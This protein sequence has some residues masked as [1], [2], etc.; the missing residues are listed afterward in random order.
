MKNITWMYIL[1]LFAILYLAVLFYN[2]FNT[3]SLHEGFQQGEPF[4]VR[5]ENEIYDDFYVEI[6]DKLMLPETRVPFE[7]EHIYKNCEY[8][9]VKNI[10]KIIFIFI[11]RC[12]QMTLHIYLSK[13]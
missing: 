9:F 1:I 10:Y 11:I 12:K 3:N 7:I 4:V 13:R 6:Y 8:E 2:H 5:R